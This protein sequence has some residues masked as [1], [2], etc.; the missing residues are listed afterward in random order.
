MFFAVEVKVKRGFAQTGIFGDFVKSRCS[1]A[2]LG[3]ESH[4][5]RYDFEGALGA[6]SLPSWLRVLLWDRSFQILNSP[7]WLGLAAM[8]PRQSSNK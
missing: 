3:K 4:G 8:R 1:K 7:K 2:L 5:S 6:A